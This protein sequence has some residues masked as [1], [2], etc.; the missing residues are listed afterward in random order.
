MKKITLTICLA[1]IMCIGVGCKNPTVEYDVETKGWELWATGVVDETRIEIN[2]QVRKFIIEFVGDLK[3]EEQNFHNFNEVK[4][5]MSGSVYRYSQRGFGGNYLYMWKEGES[6]T[7]MSPPI[8]VLDMFA[9]RM[10]AD[11]EEKAKINATTRATTLAEYKWHSAAHQPPTPGETV[12]IE[13]K[14]GLLTIGYYTRTKTWKTDVDRKK[15]SGGLPLKNVSR[16][17]LVDLR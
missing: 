5:K 2:G 7:P 3:I 11:T 1:M 9:T 14:D 10:K 8:K 6:V 17:K 16:W 12:V 13:F 4:E 15:M